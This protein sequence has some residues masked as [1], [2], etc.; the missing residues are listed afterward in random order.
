MDEAIE[1]GVSTELDVYEYTEED[2]NKLLSLLTEIDAV[3]ES[4]VTLVG[5]ILSEAEGYFSGASTA[6]QT[7]D[8]IQS[9]VDIYLAERS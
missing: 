3:Y 6:E 2:S 5:I 8:A 4:D 7:A 9:R 1:N